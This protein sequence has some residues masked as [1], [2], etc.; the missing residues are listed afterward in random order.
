MQCKYGGMTVNIGH[1]ANH[2]AIP[3]FKKSMKVDSYAIQYVRR[4]DCQRPRRLKTRKLVM[5]YFPVLPFLLF[6]VY[7]G[8]ALHFYI[9]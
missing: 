6:I 7:C 9:L 4:M 8:I 3:W 1:Y 2:S 5:S